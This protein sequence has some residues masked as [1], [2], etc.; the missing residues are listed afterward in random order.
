MNKALLGI[1][2]GVISVLTIVTIIIVV[3]AT[4]SEEFH[5]HRSSLVV[6]NE[7]FYILPKLFCFVVAA[8][9]L[10]FVRFPSFFLHPHHAPLGM[11]SILIL[12]PFE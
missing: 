10:N 4:G 6:E 12:T 9:I 2:V 3:L 5:T 8:L 7:R 11:N 1:I